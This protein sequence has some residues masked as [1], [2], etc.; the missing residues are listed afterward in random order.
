MAA[1]LLPVPPPEEDGS[2]NECHSSQRTD[3]ACSKRPRKL[4]QALPHTEQVD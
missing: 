1:G 3:D 2:G 4:M